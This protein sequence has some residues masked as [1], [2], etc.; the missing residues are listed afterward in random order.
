M[1]DILIAVG[2]EGCGM[3]PVMPYGIGRI[4][5]AEFALRARL[6]VEIA[7]VR[8]GFDVIDFPRAVSDPQDFIMLTHRSAADGAVVTSYGAFGSRR[9]FN[10][11]CGCAVRYASGRHGKRSRMLGEDV[12]ARL[13]SARPCSVNACGEYESASC[14]VVAVD[15]GYL[16]DFD[17][18][19]RSLDP[20]YARN[21]AELTVGGVCEFF[22]M[23]YIPRDD[24]EAYPI[25]G[26]APIGKRGKKIKLLQAA[27]AVNGYD[28]AVDG[29]YG[30]TTDAAVKKLCADCGYNAN[31]IT[32]EMWKILLRLEPTPLEKGSTHCHV[33]YVKQKL[34]AKLFDV[35]SGDELDEQTLESAAEYLHYVGADDC[36]TTNG[37]SLDQLGVISAV[38]GGRPRLF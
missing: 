29:V 18:A 21:I 13:R 3:S 15:G 22:G 27:L 31:G 32:P 38:G 14:P 8:C 1:K 16:T 20:D 6:Y 28:V 19:R 26:N 25:F 34:R 23:P 11:V 17:D 36:D 30:K 37:L 10:D 5:G 7:L 2:G 35:P 9:S 4:D 33:R 24:V 12:C